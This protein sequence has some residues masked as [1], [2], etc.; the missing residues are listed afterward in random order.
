MIRYSIKPTIRKCIKGYK[1]L[2]SARNLFGK[3]GTKILYTLTKREVD[4]ANTA[5]KKVIN[6]AAAA[7]GKFIGNKIAEKILIPKL[8]VEAN[9][10]AK[11]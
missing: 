7:T 10:L 1:F 11:A 5:S 3:Y 9:N 2:S 8:V 4:A 6:K